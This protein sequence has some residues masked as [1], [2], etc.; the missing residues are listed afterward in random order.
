M[1]TRERAFLADK[2]QSRTRRR[3]LFGLDIDGAGQETSYRTCCVVAIS[4]ALDAILW[5]QMRATREGSAGAPRQ[6]GGGICGPAAGRRG[7]AVESGGP[8]A[9]RHA[10]RMAPSAAGAQP[11]LHDRDN[12]EQYVRAF[13]VYAGACPWGWTSHLADEWFSDLP[14]VRNRGR[15]TV[16]G[17][18]VSLRQFCSFVTDPTYGWASECEQRVGSHPVQITNEVNAADHVSEIGAAPSKRQFTGQELEAQ[19]HH[20]DGLVATG[21]ALGRKGGLSAFRDATF[22][23]RSLRL[24][25]PPQHNPDAPRHRFRPQPG[26]TGVR[27]ERALLQPAW[28]ITPRIGTAPQRPG[29][30][31]LDHGDPRPV[32][33]RDPALA[34]PRLH[35]MPTNPAWGR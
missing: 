3:S 5:Y 4:L 24:R 12:R 10:A 13:A 2:R 19:F 6:V 15:W 9:Q 20:A 21:R 32:V 31:P 17:Y 18:E 35:R 34:R 7:A 27:G 23:R 14:A 28:Q 22:L 8:D 29:C 1:C 16:R 11:R 30:S 26:R 25:Q 33:H